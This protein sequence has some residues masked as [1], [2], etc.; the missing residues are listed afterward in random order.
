MESLRQGPDIIDVKT[1]VQKALDYVQQVYETEDIRNLGLEE[2][3]LSQDAE[4]WSVTV[5]FSR[6]WSQDKVEPTPFSTL[7]THP[8]QPKYPIDRD[9][10]EVCLDARSG[11]VRGMEIRKL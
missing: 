5:G 8:F 7:A 4:T 11:E 1:A 9:Y 10:K 3:K 6:P 2:V